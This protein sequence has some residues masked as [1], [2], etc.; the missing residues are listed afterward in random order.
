[1]CPSSRKRLE[2]PADSSLF[3]PLPI[4]SFPLSFSLFPLSLSSDHLCL[5]FPS[6]SLSSPLS[7]LPFLPPALQ[8]EDRAEIHLFGIN[9]E[10]SHLEDIHWR[11]HLDLQAMGNERTECLVLAGPQSVVLS[12][13]ILNTRKRL[14]SPSLTTILRAKCSLAPVPPLQHI[15]KNSFSKCLAPLF[16]GKA[17]FPSI[18]RVLPH[19]LGGFLVTVSQ[20]TCLSLVC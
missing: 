12:P 15:G 8:C 11:L 5:L 6:S 2:F 14:H 9:E 19:L 13:S 17:W 18:C 3:S 10:V 20:P 16:S 4:L 7:L 1:M